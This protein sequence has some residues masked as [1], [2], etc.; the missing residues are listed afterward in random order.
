MSS[1][2]KPPYA[3]RPRPERAEETQRLISDRLSDVERWSRGE[4][5]SQTWSARAEMVAR[6]IDPGLTVLDLGC[7]A[8]M[9][10]EKA[11]GPQ[12]CYI[13][14]DL[15]ARDTRTLV[16]DL[17]AGQTPE[18]EA[19]VVVMLGVI[20]Y[21]HDPQAVLDR[22]AR[23]YR[24]L[25]ATYTP[26]ELNPQQ[27]RRAHGWFN[28]LTSAGLVEMAI[29]AGFQLDAIVPFEVQRLYAFSREPTVP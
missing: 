26:V 25:I 17:N 8:N 2:A 29:A 20:E 19:D 4:N 6:L 11:L 9:D 16:C 14:A 3:H 18:V 23:R 21:L 24:R 28:D 7:G 15:V 5:F 27:D 10:L 12:T 13:P 22:L 1:P